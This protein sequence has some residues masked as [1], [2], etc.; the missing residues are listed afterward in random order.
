MANWLSGYVLS[1]SVS[2]MAKMSNLPRIS[3]LLISWNLKSAMLL[4]LI[5]PILT[6]LR[7]ILTKVSKLVKVL[8]WSS[9]SL[10]VCSV[11]LQ[12]LWLVSISLTSAKGSCFISSKQGGHIQLPFP[13]A[14]NRFY[15]LGEIPPHLIWI[16]WEQELQLTALW[17]LATTFL[18]T[19]QL[20]GPGLGLMSPLR[21][22]SSK[23]KLATLLL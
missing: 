2:E 11:S 16:R 9:F 13:E 19:M 22:S 12:E 21:R 5:W 1:S 10:R 4:V 3:Q 6:F 17:F 23:L 18:Q 7:C 15:S 20:S 14:C 8:L